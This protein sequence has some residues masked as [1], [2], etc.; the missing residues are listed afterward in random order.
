MTGRIDV[1]LDLPRSRHMSAGMQA[2]ADELSARLP[3]VAPD[4]TFATLA[5]ETTLDL[6]E[7]LRLPAR[8]RR[9]RPRLVHFLSV[10][11]P[12]AA[13]RPF[14]LTIHDLIHLRFPEFHKRTVAPYYALV[15]RNLCARAARVI[16]DDERTVGDLGR[17]LGVPPEKVRVVPLGVDD[18]FLSDVEPEAVPRPFFLYVGNHRPHKDL[19]TLFAAWAALDPALEVDLYL[20][21]PDDLPPGTPRPGRA[22]GEVRFLG[23][24]GTERLARLYRSALALVHPALSEGFGLPLLEASAVGARVIA[25]AGAVPGVLR[26]Y[27]AAFPAKDVR[28]LGALMTQAVGRSPQS[29]ESRL[30]ARTF[31]WDRCARETAGVYREVLEETRGR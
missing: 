24:V 29:E 9:L 23:D 20:T 25:C 14:A 6:A 3:R 31:G 7:Q 22:S 27:V 15:V 10:Y 1:A 2:Y 17:F 18:R 30:F 11:A 19:A 5:R 28:A 16:T 26:P 4:L 13:P 12:F 21:G 8:L